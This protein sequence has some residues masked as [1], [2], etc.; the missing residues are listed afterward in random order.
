LIINPLPSY[1]DFKEETT[2]MLI[3]IWR[4]VIARTARNEAAEAIHWYAICW[5]AW[6]NG[7]QWRHYRINL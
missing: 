5:I 3:Q 1:S 6:P 4:L 2:V 7:S